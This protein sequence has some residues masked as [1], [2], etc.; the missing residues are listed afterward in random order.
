MALALLVGAGLLHVSAVCAGNAVAIAPDDDEAA[1]ASKAAQV[2]PSAS[3]LAWQQLGLTAFV[4]FG[5]PTYLGVEGGDGRAPVSRFNPTALDTDQWARALKDG[6]FRLA[7][8]TVKHADGF[9]LHDSALSDYSAAHSPYRGDVLRRFLASM[10]AHGIRVGIYFSPLNRHEMNVRASDWNP[11]YPRYGYSAVKPRQPCRVPQTPVQGAPAFSF[12]TDE[13]NCLYMR[14]LYELF[15]RYGPID[16]W[17]I[18]GNSTRYTPDPKGWDAFRAWPGAQG[19]PTQRYDNASWYQIASA[20]QPQMLAFG[21]WDIRWVGN[22]E[23]YARVGGEWSTIAIR[24]GLDDAF[25]VAN[26]GGAPGERDTW[27]GA[28]HLVWWP[29]EVDVPI[30]ASGHWFHRAG[31]QPQ[32]LDKLW[33]FHAAS[34]G[35]NANL[36]L[37]FSPDQSGRIPADQVQAA[38][39]LREKIERVFG[40]DLGGAAPLR[41]SRD[42][43]VV[44]RRL[45][46]PATFDWIGLGEDIAASGQRVEAFDIEV[47]QAGRWQ[48]VRTRTW[49]RAGERIADETAR[50][51]LRRYL[52]LAQPVTTT[53]VRVRVTASRME[54]AIAVFTLHHEGPAAAST[55]SS[56]AEKANSA[57]R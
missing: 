3:Q 8:L 23:G 10:R 43:R 15:S 31:D 16:E 13:Y 4:H 17:W 27:R 7:V 6:G 53:R 38:R 32:P 48:P 34:V 49:N 50:I 51:G 36:L 37:N 20:L 55:A 30:L 21:G 47:W 39:Q 45:A 28:R 26:P 2:R 56:T 22:E 9:L 18:D 14:Q 41:R 25:P 29:T 35:R 44:E 33:Q 5:M 57:I 24:N 40:T 11:A 52:Q 42:G 1:I 46:Q 54:P 12:Q 19:D